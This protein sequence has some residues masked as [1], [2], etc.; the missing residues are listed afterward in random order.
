M[1]FVNVSRVLGVASNGEASIELE[2]GVDEAERNKGSQLT[3]LPHSKLDSMNLGGNPTL[4]N[5]SSCQ[6]GN[7]PMG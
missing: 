5:K 4:K 6:V 1:L 3:L 7:D 2:V